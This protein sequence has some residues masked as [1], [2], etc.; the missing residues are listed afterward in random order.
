MAILRNTGI[1]NRITTTSSAIISPQIEDVD[2][3]KNLQTIC[4]L[5]V[6]IFKKN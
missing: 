1:I 4:I 3:I 6:S 5:N 2:F